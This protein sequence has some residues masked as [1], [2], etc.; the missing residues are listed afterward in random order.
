MAKPKEYLCAKSFDK[1]H[2]YGKRFFVDNPYSNFKPGVYS[3][4]L[5]RALGMGTSDVS[6]LLDRMKR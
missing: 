5:K 6:P 2:R 1:F 4:E 3:D